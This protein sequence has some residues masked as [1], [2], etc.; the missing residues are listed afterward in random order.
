M[1]VMAN[2]LRHF[3]S[4]VQTYAQAATELRSAYQTL[5]E[6]VQALQAMWTGE[7]HDSL[8]Q[9]FMGDY[10]MLGSVVEYLEAMGASLENAEQEYTSCESAVSGII[11]G[12]SF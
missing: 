5:L 1:S 9:R 3:G 11:N 12:L 8:E 10:Q 2:E 6:D 4:D 7:A